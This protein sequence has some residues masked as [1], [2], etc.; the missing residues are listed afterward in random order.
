MHSSPKCEALQLLG[1][2]ALQVGSL[3]PIKLRVLQKPQL[4]RKANESTSTCGT[5]WE[6]PVRGMLIC[7]KEETQGSINELH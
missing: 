7:N 5:A 1:K 2:A 3:K 6:D 4:S